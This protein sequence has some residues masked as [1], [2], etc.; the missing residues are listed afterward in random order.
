[1]RIILLCVLVIG[2]FSLQAQVAISQC[3]ASYLGTA[4]SGSVT[5]TN[6]VATGN[7]LLVY[8]GSSNASPTLTIT[9]S[10]GN[11]YTQVT[12]SPFIPT[13]QSL[14]ASYSFFLSNNITGGASFAVNLS[15]ASASMEL[16]ACEVSLQ[17]FTSLLDQAASV[18]NSTNSVASPSVTTGSNGEL[19][20][21]IGTNAAGGALTVGSGFSSNLVIAPANTNTLIESKTQT[22]AGAV[23]A[24][25]T[26]SGN[27]TQMTVITLRTITGTLN[28]VSVTPNPGSVF[29]QSTAQITATGAYS[30][31]TNRD[32]TALSTWG[33]SNNGVATINSSGVATGVAPGSTTITATYSAHSGNA[34]LNDVDPQFD[35]DGGLWVSVCN[36][37][38]T[39]KWYTEKSSNR[40]W[41]CTPH[42]HHFFFE[43]VGA[44]VYPGDGN[45]F[46]G[47]QGT[48][49]VTAKY[50]GSVDA[51]ALAVQKEFLAYNFNAVGELGGRGT[52]TTTPCIGCK[53]L[54]QI[55]TFELAGQ[56]MFLRC[57][58]ATTSG[59]L[60]TALSGVNPLKNIGWG[61][62]SNYDSQNFK[63]LGDGFDS[64][65]FGGYL[66]AYFAGDTGFLAY[67]AS[68]KFIG[69]MGDDSDFVPGIGAGPDFDAAGYGGG[70]NDVNLGRF[71]LIASPIQT[72]SSSPYARELL[73]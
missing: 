17:A 48:S 30:D 25:A 54:P 57:R 72:W 63:R 58:P 18:S 10:R 32:V 5:F 1:M 71:V 26:V 40:W 6:N 67:K 29:T 59:P 50:G 69:I 70:K 45:Y 14:W 65:A 46:G 38:T 3:K 43:G 36:G 37:G 66:D 13:T 53:Q 21:G 60:C 34:T 12:G 49:I 20:L 11:S 22:S 73:N 61:L 28:S 44:W 8:V 9:D 47:D 31:S 35:A 68:G 55:Q 19:I 16:A 41:F 4:T 39:S 7:A 27:F 33:S 64:V 51:S 15:T 2:S 24:T 23:T 52:D 62:D 56:A 42:G